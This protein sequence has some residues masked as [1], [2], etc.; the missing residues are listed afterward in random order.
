MREIFTVFDI[1]RT[2]SYPSERLP[3]LLTLESIDFV[4]AEDEYLAVVI[5]K[6]TSVSSLKGR[7]IDVVDGSG[8][9]GGS[10]RAGFCF[11]HV[12]VIILSR[13][14][15]AVCRTAI[16]TGHRKRES[17]GLCALRS[18][19]AR[20]CIECEGGQLSLRIEDQRADH[21]DVLVFDHQFIRR[22]TGNLR[23]CDISGSFRRC[24]GG[25]CYISR[26][27]SYW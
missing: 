23:P 24:N 16:Q 6:P 3:H 21:I 27:R 13:H 7:G 14:G 11:E 8:Y 10:E 18:A 26:L 1:F 25:G 5:D 4:S 9:A 15:V 19:I 2:I 20:R 17:C 22:S 12:A